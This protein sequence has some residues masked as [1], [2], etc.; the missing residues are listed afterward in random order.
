MRLADRCINAFALFALTLLLAAG[1]VRTQACEVR[2][3]TGTIGDPGVQFSLQSYQEA[4]RGPSQSNEVVGSYYEDAR[5]IPIRL[6][7]VHMADGRIT[8]CEQSPERKQGGAPGQGVA[9]PA[10][11]PVTLS[12]MEHSATGEWR[13]KRAVR[14][15]TLKQVGQIERTEGGALLTGTIEIPMW[16][17]TATHLYLGIYESTK[18]CPLAMRRLRLISIATGHAE[19]EV[20][21]DEATC[22]AGMLMTMIYANVLE[23]KRP[24]HVR[25][26]FDGGHHGHEEDINVRPP[27][28]QH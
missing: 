10:K 4:R 23:S 27:A 18:G 17:H 20:P 25:V 12:V 16:Y 15:I 24:H 13:D 2:N 28:R 5:R 7:G 9:R 19:A 1:S 22:D 11:C 21:L 26:G 8:L 14:R 3:F 6:S